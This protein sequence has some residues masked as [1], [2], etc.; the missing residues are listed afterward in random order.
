MFLIW[1]QNM[2]LSFIPFQA[3]RLWFGLLFLVYFSWFFV[4]YHGLWCMLSLSYHRFSYMSIVILFLFSFLFLIRVFISCIMT[5]NITIAISIIMALGM[6][7][8]HLLRRNTWAN[9]H[10]HNKFLILLLFLIA[11]FKH[12]IVAKYD[13]TITNYLPLTWI[14]Q[15]IT[16]IIITIT[17]EKHI[18]LISSQAYFSFQIITKQT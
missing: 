17:M 10:I 15:P 1:S 3:I 5:I 14:P 16:S 9:M 4:D 6:H 18:S 7:F 2:L 11:F 13:I 12:R 8:L